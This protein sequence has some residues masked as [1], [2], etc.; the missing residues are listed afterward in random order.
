[1]SEWGQY[2]TKHFFDVF[3]IKQ[4]PTDTKINIDKIIDLTSKAQSVGSR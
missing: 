3:K 4:S 2:D 1:M